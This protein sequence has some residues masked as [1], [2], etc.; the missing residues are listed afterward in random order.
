[1]KV[2]ETAKKLRGINIRYILFFLSMFFVLLGFIVFKIENKFSTADNIIT[3]S[4]VL[5]I[6]IFIMT[7]FKYKLQNTYTL[8][9]KTEK[10]KIKKLIFYFLLP[11]FCFSQILFSP[12]V[13]GLRHDWTIPY[14]K[15]QLNSFG[16]EE[17]HSWMEKS[18]G[19]PI[20][21]NSQFLLKIAVGILG[22]LGLSPEVISKLFLIAPMII[23]GF[24]AYFLSKSL[25]MKDENAF[26]TG[27]FYMLTPL[28]FIK[29]V[30]G[31]ILY[32]VSYA[33]APLCLKYFIEKKPLK[34]GLVFALCGVQIQFFPMLFTML[35]IYSFFSEDWKKHLKILIIVCIIA[36]LIH[37][38][39][40][41]AVF[42]NLEKSMQNASS[43]ATEDWIRFLSP[44]LTEIITLLGFG[45]FE[46]VLLQGTIPL[47]VWGMVS[48]AV[49]A[50]V[51]FSI[52]LQPKNKIIQYFTL[53][54][55]ISLFLCKGINPPFGEIFKILLYNFPLTAMFR[56]VF[57]LMFMLT[58]SY[59]ILFGF[60]LQSISDKIKKSYLFPFAI[61]LILIYSWPF[62]T[63]NA[64]GNI[65]TVKIP[66]AY[67]ELYKE[68]QNENGEF[69]IYWTPG[70]F[71]ITYRE[72]KYPGVDTLIAY[73]PKPS[74]D[75]YILYS[76]GDH[77]T[78]FIDNLMHNQGTQYLGDILS[79]SSVKY[80][81]WRN[82]FYSKLP[83]FLYDKT[84]GKKFPEFENNYNNEKIK[85]II[86]RQYDL[87]F[88]SDINETINCAKIFENLNFQEKIRL[89]SPAIASSDL[90]S[91]IT[92]KY[93]NITTDL[94]FAK[95]ADK[96]VFDLI[97]E[98]IIPENDYNSLIEPL[99]KKEN[100]IE[101]GNLALTYSDASKGWT[102]LNLWWWYN[103]KQA[104]TINAGIITLNESVFNL[105]LNIPENDSYI[106]LTKTYN[107]PKGSTI[108]LAMDSFE[109]DEIKTKSINEEGYSW[110]NSTIFLTKGRH[111][112]SLNSTQGENVVDNIIIVTENDYKNALN[113]L[114][115]ILQNKKIYLTYEMEKSFETGFQDEN[116]SLGS[117]AQLRENAETSKK[118]WIPKTGIY[119]IRARVKGDGY[120]NN[121]SVNSTNYI[122]IELNP[123][124]LEQSW[125]VFKINATGISSDILLFE[126][127][128]DVK[129]EINNITFNKINPAEYTFS[130]NISSNSF[131]I[132][133]ERFD[134]SWKMK[135][136]EHFTVNSFANAFYLNKTGNL[137]FVIKTTNE[138]I[139][140]YLLIFSLF[141]IMAFI[142]LGIKYE[143]Q[144]TW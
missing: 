123:E 103:W 53:I 15:E 10:I 54:A 132:F 131:L 35:L 16:F 115:K 57:N 119:K 114:N 138:G 59:S 75:G 112:F 21:Y 129:T 41:Y 27:L 136:F 12:G 32:L 134:D 89:S 102:N 127:N 33:L 106:V 3:I 124:Y 130:T 6:L 98:V 65:Q 51:F 91:F 48:F 44:N 142:F 71:P 79:K 140:S 22:L 38:P 60:A 88:I 34:S 86:E 42:S 30:S 81:I 62:F 92:A 97:N 1:M 67:H 105:N 100:V 37:L 135:D 4:L 117:A 139:Y 11:V 107:S 82:D 8:A 66:E 73:S 13:I 74:L 20:S 24:S 94:I 7:K 120:F 9:Q 125:N 68:L 58:I 144:T 47:M 64:G 121:I 83:K 96:K 56:E 55:L 133:S 78:T 80:I 69:R 23:S 104:S 126:S 17:L 111:I 19:T 5:W 122:W 14:F 72:L 52:L 141:S 76:Y 116:A 26:L 128:E 118:V 39:W 63:T 143:N 40:I 46:S 137:N 36:G 90:T 29:I 85:E 43:M 95:Q 84:N 45:Y 87:K 77:Y 28:M 18:L 99:L 113:E 2:K 31:H 50:L 110:H 93:A 49:I 25:K 108:N 70:V 61:I 109:F 101:P